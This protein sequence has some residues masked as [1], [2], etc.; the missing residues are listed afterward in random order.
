M[1]MMNWR[2]MLSVIISL[3]TGFACFL[4][5]H[6]FIFPLHGKFLTG[7]DGRNNAPRQMIMGME[8]AKMNFLLMVLVSFFDEG[9]SRNVT[10]F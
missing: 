8:I 7:A 4:R 2:D 10:E 3:F 6:S 9:S 5:Q 1:M